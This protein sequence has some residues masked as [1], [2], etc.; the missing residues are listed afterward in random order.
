[1]LIEEAKGLF[2][3]A[4]PQSGH[5]LSP[6]FTADKETVVKNHKGVLEKMG[7]SAVYIKSV[8]GRYA[9]AET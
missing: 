2:H 5:A 4:I 1:M 3:R 8:M 6:G 9:K 7:M